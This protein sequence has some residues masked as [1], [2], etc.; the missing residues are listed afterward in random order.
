[1][2][3]LRPWHAW[4]ALSI[5]GC[6]SGDGVTVDVEPGCIAAAELAITVTLLPSGDSRTVSAAGDT[7]FGGSHEVAV[8]V[9][10]GATGVM[11]AVTALDSAMRTVGSGSVT[12]PI[13][14]H[15]MFQSTLVLDGECADAGVR[16]DLSLPSPDLRADLSQS[17]LLGADLLGADLL[18]GASDMRQRFCPQDGAVLCSDFDDDDPDASV[19]GP[20]DYLY[21]APPGPTAGVSGARY[22][23]APRSFL[24]QADNAAGYSAELVKGFTNITGATVSFDLYIEV[25]GSN[26]GVVAFSVSPTNSL[27]LQPYDDTTSAILEASLDA[28]GGYV[29]NSAGGPVIPTGQWVHVDFSVTLGQPSAVV[30]IDHLQTISWTPVAPVWATATAL[31]VS[32]GIPNTHGCTLYFDNV[33][34]RTP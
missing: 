20:W 7:F 25:R 9:P 21:V 32:L 5:A 28:D 29:Y 30:K 3:G 19:P 23:T 8:V 16:A 18:Q 34:I 12:V 14:G 26:L 10:D 15:G 17:D 6:S 31:N 1:M 11:V 22:S 13:A 27:L 2:S 24:V 33:T 4:I